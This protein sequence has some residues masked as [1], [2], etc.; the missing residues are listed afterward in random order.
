MSNVYSCPKC[1]ESIIIEPND[2]RCGQFVHAI[3]KSNM[4]RVNP[5]SKSSFV[6]KLIKSG[7]VFGCG[8]FFTLNRH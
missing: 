3:Y 8:A 5:H 6:Q 7:K 2:F 4:K 1:N